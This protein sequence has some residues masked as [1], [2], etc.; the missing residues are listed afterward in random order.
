MDTGELK[1]MRLQE[2]MRLEEKTTLDAFA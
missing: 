2:K 1:E